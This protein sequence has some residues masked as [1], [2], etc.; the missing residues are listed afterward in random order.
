MIS[1]GRWRKVEDLFGAAL[2]LPP[3]ERDRFLA[4]ECEGDDALRLEVESLLATSGKTDSFLEERGR[5]MRPLAA[6]LR[7]ELLLGRNLGPYHVEA[8]LGEGGMGIV[9]RATDTRNGMAVAVKVLPPEVVADRARRRRFALEARAASALDHPNIAKV[10]EIG[11]SEA[12]DFI[13]M[14]F[15]AGQPLQA[16][17]GAA[18]PLRDALS[19]AIQISSALAA[20][21]AAG[22]VHRDIKPAN[23]LVTGSGVVKLVDFGLC[24]LTEPEETPRESGY[25]LTRE[26]AIVGTTAYMSPE[27]A[28]GKPADGRSDIFS[29]GS[30]LYEMVTGEPAFRGETPIS[31][32][33]AI[34]RG[35]P[36][37]MC[38][39]VRNVPPPVEAVILRCLAKDPAK[40]YQTAVD[41]HAA[42]EDLSRRLDAGKLRAPLIPARYRKRVYAAVIFCLIVAAGWG[43]WRRPR[44]IASGGALAQLTF[45]SGLT[46]DPTF[47]PDG[48]WLAYASDRGAANLSI[49]VQR[50]P[51]GK[52]VRLTEDDADHREPSLAPDGSQ[53]VFRAEHDGGGIYAV[54]T[55]GGREQRI[56]PSGRRPRFSPDG[57]WIAYW[58]GAEGSGDPVALG[59]SKIF[60]VP[61][62][63]GEPRPI[64][65]G[66]AI[67]RSPIWFPDGK[68]LLFVG[69]REANVSVADASPW[70]A[71]PLDGA[72]A[73]EAVPPGTFRRAWVLDP[74]TPGAWTPDHHV[75]AASDVDDLW[76]VPVSAQTRK[77]T[78]PPEKVNLGIKSQESPASTLAGRLAVSNAEL[79]SSLWILPIATESA[80]LAGP[81]VRV[82]SGDVLKVGF[83]SLSPD[84]RR[85]CY[86]AWTR[87]G[88]ALWKQSLDT[89]RFEPLA[90]HGGDWSSF[91]PDGASVA[92]TASPAGHQLLFV[93]PWEGG[94]AR[95][96]SDRV[97]RV[98][99]FSPDGK[100]VLDFS[101]SDQPRPIMLVDA[102]YG[103][104]RE[105]LRH[106]LWNL[107]LAHFSTDGRWIVFT[108]K[109]APDRSQ[110]F[111]AP[112]T[113]TAPIPVD[114]WIPVTGGSTVDSHAWWSPAGG[115]IYF[116]SERL[117][118]V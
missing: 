78:G 100:Y 24:K 59:S 103:E 10:F 101:P 46:T 34:L 91:R 21:H 45:D 6:A 44:E 116:F 104:R 69:S 40:R 70:W 66:F 92:Y 29:F 87:E 11:D 47:S 48:R 38:D 58:V 7:S 106:P 41:L 31:T 36:R 85:L 77:I 98:W 52:P 3:A 56:A 75:I 90:S 80:R 26:G 9:Y 15:V 94:T 95:M 84:G 16:L 35:E 86:A 19:I 55:N 61:S 79:K 23:V 102:Q 62:N 114:R 81:P 25:S 117:G 20:A 39:V 32:L 4:V 112:F 109:T 12:W 111:V 42:L 73:I 57:R 71:T 107:Y 67:A 74:L 96:V 83:P 27:Q 53:V 5:V 88:Q 50:L 65:P 99:D 89:S 63:G 72:P 118:L 49:W 68:Y 17:L 60:V 18:L 30:V 14:E 93:M 28:E 97:I 2:D 8:H 82:V 64:Q 115:R 105:L 1:D 108:A 110:I 43:I 22:I 76:Q 51:N 13:A 37:P 113:G 54:S 33:A